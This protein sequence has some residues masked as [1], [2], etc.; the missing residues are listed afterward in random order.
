MEPI[1]LSK[2]QKNKINIINNEIKELKELIND[3]EIIDDDDF[4]YVLSMIQEF[5]EKN[6]FLENE[7]KAVIDPLNVIR[8][9]I[10]SWFNP[11]IKEIDGYI[12]ILKNKIIEYENQQRQRLCVVQNDKVTYRE[13]WDYEIVDFNKIPK[14]FLSLDHSAVKIEIRNKKEETHI[15]GIRI[16]SNKTPIIK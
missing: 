15:P 8:N 2:K 7:R 11:L 4:D 14:R 6:S 9:K 12:K 16:F 3:Y 5:K 1:K 10:N 13:F